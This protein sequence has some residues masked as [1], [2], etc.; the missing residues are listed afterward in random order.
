MTAVSCPRRLSFSARFGRRAPAARARAAA[1]TRSCPPRE[2]QE[3][4]GT[5]RGP[6][7]ALGAEPRGLGPCEA[8]PPRAR[9]PR[10]ASC[11]GVV[12]EAG[13]RALRDAVWVKKRA[14][15]SLARGGDASTHGQGSSAGAEERGRVGA[16]SVFAG[17]EWPVSAMLWPCEPP[18]MSEMGSHVR[19]LTRVRVVQAPDRACTCVRSGA[20]CFSGLEV[21]RDHALDDM[22]L[23][24]VSETRFTS[25]IP[26]SPA[27]HV[28]CRCSRSCAWDGI[29]M[30]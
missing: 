18:R 12:H 9:E 27:A 24:M 3:V 6:A 13:M 5:A 16:P 8:E 1:S 10:D 29:V 7:L 25:Q 4:A 11:E 28:P 22:P 21:P 2:F 17:G 14:S 23:P 19:F 20:Q 15:C 26:G 30:L